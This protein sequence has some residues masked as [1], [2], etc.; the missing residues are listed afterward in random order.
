MLLSDLDPEAAHLRMFNKPYKIWE[1]NTNA[2][3][4]NLARAGHSVFLIEAGEDH[5]DERIQQ[6]PALYASPVPYSFCM[7]TC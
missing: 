4:A 3:S 5:G 7:H 6:M 2:D 1:H